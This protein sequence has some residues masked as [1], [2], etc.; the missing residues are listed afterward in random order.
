MSK[1]IEGIYFNKPNEKSPPYIKAKMKF[2]RDKLISWLKE[3]DEEFYAEMKESKAGS[4]YGAVDDW[5]PTKK[6][7]DA[8]SVSKAV[9]EDD[10][11]LPF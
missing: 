9:K 3:Q 6:K 11:E 10:G 1:L 8:K 7:D 2:E 5:K 4:F